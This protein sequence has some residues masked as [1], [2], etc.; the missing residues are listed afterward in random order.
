MLTNCYIAVTILLRRH[1]SP[2]L[3]K[4]VA[5]DNSH[6]PVENEI[7]GVSTNILLPFTWSVPEGDGISTPASLLQIELKFGY[8]HP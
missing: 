8:L 7:V 2:S 6:I 3:L 4:L 5:G 1:E